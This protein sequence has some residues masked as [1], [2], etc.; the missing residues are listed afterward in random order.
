LVYKYLSLSGRKEKEKFQDLK[1][2]NIVIAKR[3]RED[4][5]Y[6]KTQIGANKK[7]FYD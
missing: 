5:C 4:N 1:Y 7:I 2:K 3:S 6:C